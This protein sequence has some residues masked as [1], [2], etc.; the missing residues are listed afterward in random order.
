MCKCVLIV[1]TGVCVR[2]CRADA[3]VGYVLPSISTTF[4]GQCF[5]LYLELTTGKFLGSSCLCLA[6]SDI[7]GVHDCAQISCGY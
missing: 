4:L 2:V 1:C 3:D 6:S 7:E 5:S